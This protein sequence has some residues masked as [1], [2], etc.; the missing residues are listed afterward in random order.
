MNTITL[1]FEAVKVKIPVENLTFESLEEMIFDIR[2]EIGRTAFVKALQQYDEALGISR[3]RG[4]LENICKK[5][6][7]LQ[8]RAGDITYS[9]TLYKEKTTGKPRYLLNEASGI[10]VNQRKSLKMSQ[11]TTT[12]ASFA[13]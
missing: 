6:K 11:L 12:L 9:R 2:Q 4:T 1:E 7:C 5:T 3:R 8:T 13:S 10:E